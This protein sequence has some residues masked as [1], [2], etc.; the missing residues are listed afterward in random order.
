M[1]RWRVSRP[2]MDFAMRV[3]PQSRLEV[4]NE[5]AVRGS[6]AP[7]IRCATGPIA[8]RVAC[9]ADHHGR[10]DRQWREA[11][12]SRLRAAGELWLRTPRVVD[13]PTPQQLHASC[14]L[15]L[16]ERRPA[17]HLYPRIGARAATS[18]RSL[19]RASLR[20]SARHWTRASEAAFVG[21]MAC[22]T[23]AESR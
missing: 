12:R 2:S 8:S 14:A 22:A 1:R 10:L 21:E 3:T 7:V 16:L 23:T 6:S 20:E 18:S 15:A 9:A 19:G 5:R 17:L 13:L 4:L 11:S